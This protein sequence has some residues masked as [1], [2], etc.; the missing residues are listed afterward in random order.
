VGSR[1]DVVAV[2]DVRKMKV[3]SQHRHKYQVKKKDRCLGKQQKA[4]DAKFY[5][6]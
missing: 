4:K 5:C 3:A 6:C 2:A 1:D